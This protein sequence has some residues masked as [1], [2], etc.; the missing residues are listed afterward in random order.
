[1][2]VNI[3]ASGAWTDA[4]DVLVGTA[5]T[6]LTVQ[7]AWTDADDGFS[8]LAHLN[9][10]AQGA[11]TD[12]ADVLAG[13]AQTAIFAHG[14]WVDAVDVLAGIGV[15][16]V[17]GIGYWTDG[18]DT[19]TPGQA[20]R[21]EAQE[22]M[23]RLES[24]LHLTPITLLPPTG[25]TVAHQGVIG[26]VWTLGTIK[27]LLVQARLVYGSSGTKITVY[28]QTSLD[29]GVSWFDIMCLTFTTASAVKVSAVKAQ[30]AVM[31]SR[32]PTD[33]SLADD[34]IQDGLLGDRFRVKYT[35]TGTY[36]DDSLL[37]VLA[38]TKE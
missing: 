3:D 5:Q 20:L 4:A 8:G 36:A 23:T 7:G 15:V 24:L 35:T 2:P 26:P 28:V 11:W 12:A 1:M 14:S 30:T 27:E 6:A 37:A 17:Q 22:L 32:T 33:G 25:I 34:T 31:A 10:T 13:I 38:L 16:N 9:M 18:P 21:T 29:Q 19:L